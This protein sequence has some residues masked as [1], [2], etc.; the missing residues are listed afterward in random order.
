MQRVDGETVVVD[1]GLAALAVDADVPIFVC[2]AVRVSRH[3]EAVNDSALE[4][5][6]AG[7]G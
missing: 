2:Q 4:G 3:I 6:L 7:K 5:H 1:D